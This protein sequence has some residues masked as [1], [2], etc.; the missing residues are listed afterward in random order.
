MHILTHEEYILL[1]RLLGHH[2]VGNSNQPLER[3]AH[4]LL[5]YAERNGE[6]VVPLQLSEATVHGHPMRIG[7]SCNNLREGV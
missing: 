3:L 7:F 2:L 4:K 5:D 1:A 6:Q